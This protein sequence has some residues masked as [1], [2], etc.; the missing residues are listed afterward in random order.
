MLIY[1]GRFKE[2]DAPG[3]EDLNQDTNLCALLW[4]CLFR[5]IPCH[6]LDGGTSNRDCLLKE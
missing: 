4:F 2:E 6:L 3:A 5:D 1:L